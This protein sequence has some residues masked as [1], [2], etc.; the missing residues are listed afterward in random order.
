MWLGAHF[1]WETCEQRCATMIVPLLKDKPDYDHLH[2]LIK[3]G[4]LVYYTCRG[5][6]MDVILMVYLIVRGLSGEYFFDTHW[7]LTVTYR[8]DQIVTNKTLQEFL[9]SP[10]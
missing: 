7:S 5:R 10:Q 1:N 3:F 4:Y 8:Q 9:L 2:G 6:K